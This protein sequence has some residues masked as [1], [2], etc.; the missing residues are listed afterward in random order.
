M[1]PAI[2]AEHHSSYGFVFVWLKINKVKKCSDIC[3]SIIV[4]V[5]GYVI[6]YDLENH[7]NYM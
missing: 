5:I 3:V 6:L 7:L 4:S 1:K 2:I